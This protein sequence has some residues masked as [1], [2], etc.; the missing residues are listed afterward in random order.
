MDFRFAFPVLFLRASMDTP[1]V[2]NQITGCV[3]ATL[4]TYNISHILVHRAI[5]SLLM[6]VLR[7]F[8]TGYCQPPPPGCPRNIYKLMVD[9]WW[10]QQW[11]TS[12]NLKLASVTGR[13]I[14]WV[15]IIE[16]FIQWLV[17]TNCW[18]EHP[19]SNI[20][21]HALTAMPTANTTCCLV[22]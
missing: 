4:Y 12:Q 17:G 9:C 20:L 10:V 22:I 3:E 19:P 1:W 5:P 7:A 11:L 18:S 15:N 8:E 2:T 6:Q 16:A 13:Y 14:L 21:V